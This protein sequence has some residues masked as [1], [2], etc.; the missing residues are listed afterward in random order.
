MLIDEYRVSQRKA[1]ALSGIARS[2]LRY[3]PRPR[4]DAGVI[5]FIKCYLGAHPRQG[6]DQNQQQKIC[7]TVVSGRRYLLALFKEHGYESSLLRK[8]ILSS[9]A[10]RRRHTS[11]E[12]AP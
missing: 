12:S 2:S 7:N 8:T 3:V 11:A 9:D 6:F 10:F 4:D 1:C 5:A